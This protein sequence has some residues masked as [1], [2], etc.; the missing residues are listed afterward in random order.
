MRR[1]GFPSIPC[2]ERR[3]QIPLH[4]DPSVQKETRPKRESG[5]QYA[6]KLLSY[7]GRSEKEMFRRLRMK[8]FD[9]PTIKWIIVRLKSSGLLD[10]RRLASSLKRYAE[11][12]KQLSISGTRRFLIERGVPADMIDEVA[13]DIDEM[14]NAKKLVEKKLTVW[15]KRVPFH[16][17]S[18]FTPDMFKKLYGMLYRRGFPSETIKKALE[19][20]KLKEDV[21]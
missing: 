8:G 20:F 10:D 11:E 18:Q 13:E 14:E 4:E 21:G 2:N 19:Q 3:K 6:Y 7:R 9:E 1:E 16:Q 12:S 15:R 5:L 17:P